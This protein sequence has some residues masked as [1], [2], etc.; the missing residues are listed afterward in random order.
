METKSCEEFIVGFCPNE[1][2]YVEH[3]TAKCPHPHIASERNEYSTAK[4]AYSFEHKVLEHFK[5]ILDEVDKKVAINIQVTSKETVDESHYDALNECESLIELKNPFDFDFEKIHSLLVLHGRLIEHIDL[6]K[7]SRALDVCKNCG[8]FKE[9]SKPCIHKFC[10]KY[11]RLRDIVSKL[12]R[13]LP[14]KPTLS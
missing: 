11:Q 14:Q 1:E 10:E 3:V 9:Y 8:A 12:E 7:T 4:A 2:F 13:K 5:E 6:S